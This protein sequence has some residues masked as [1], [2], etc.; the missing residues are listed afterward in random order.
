MTTTATVTCSACGLISNPNRKSKRLG[1]PS[2]IKK[3]E[4]CSGFFS[5]ARPR[6]TGERIVNWIPTPVFTGVTFFRW[7][8][9]GDDV[10]RRFLGMRVDF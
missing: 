8:D 4:Q 7:N 5:P 2:P 9:D 10:D 1:N 6:E 3:P